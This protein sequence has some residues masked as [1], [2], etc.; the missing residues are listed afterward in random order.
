[1][2]TEP[3][4][5]LERF[6]LH[7]P[8]L[9]AWAAY[10][11]AN[12]AM[13]TTIVTAVFPIYFH[14]VAAAGWE[15]KQALQAY[16]LT[17]TL[18]LGTVAIAAPLLG[19]VADVRGWRKRLLSVFLILGILSTA[20]MF[21]VGHGDASLA[22]VL[23]FLAN[24]GAAGSFVFYDALLPHLASSEEVDRVSTSAY[25]LGYLGGGILL[26]V[27]LL[28]IQ[29]PDW[30]GLPHG[31]G[32]TPSQATLPTRLAFLSVAV[33]WAVFSIP[34]LYNV[35][36][37]PAMHKPDETP[38]ASTFKIAVGR[39]KETLTELR[40]SRDAFWMML[41]FLLYND[42]IQTIIR[43]ATYLGTL[44]EFDKGTL[45]TSILLV[46]FV[47]IPF[48]LLFGKLADWIGVRR[49]IYIGVFSYVGIT[50][51]AIFMNTALHF[52][53]LAIG[54]GMV[55]GGTQALSRSLF[56]T[57]IPRHKSSEFF[58]LFGVLEKF[59]GILGPAIFTMVVGFLPKGKESLAA[60]GILPFFLLGAL[61]LSKVNIQRGRARAREQELE[62]RTL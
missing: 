17:T 30:F 26:A 23:F 15:S 2:S 44:K 37:P 3:S 61:V 53:G 36:E 16:S 10:D 6:G 19:P 58:A 56:A 62:V 20:G 28:W 25:A 33:W 7:R 39:L 34:L 8:E 13:V 22:L 55:M 41:A 40:E 9:R 12:S 5:L 47:G 11:W 59:A 57:L 45:I 29:H 43:M 14:A 51:A 32:I 49:A 24:V 54:V 4:R 27:N 52:F 50:L 18:A 1:M 38:G 42:G 60:F 21:F 46:Q 35:P 31:E 48:A